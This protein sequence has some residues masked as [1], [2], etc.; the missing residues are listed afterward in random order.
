MNDTKRDW[1]A[2]PARLNPCDPMFYKAD[3][4]CGGIRIAQ[5]VGVGEEE[6]N[7][8]ARL[9]AAAPELLKACRFIYNELSGTPRQNML[10]IGRKILK[11]AIIKAE[12]I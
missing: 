4:I 2:K 11:E 12:I 8:N 7:A 9:V 6:A 1:V 3:V 10:V 5:V